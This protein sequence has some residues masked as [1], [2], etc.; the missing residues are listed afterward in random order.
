MAKSSCGWSAIWLYCKIWV[1]KTPSQSPSMD[2]AMEREKDFQPYICEGLGEQMDKQK[3]QNGKTL[4]EGWHMR[5]NTKTQD[6]Q[7]QWAKFCFQ[8]CFQVD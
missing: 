3:T 1:K 8:F 7:N 6:K 5:R 2:M 4:G